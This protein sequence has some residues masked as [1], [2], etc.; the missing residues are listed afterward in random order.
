M[1]S[2]T[3]NSLMSTVLYDMSSH[4]DVILSFSHCSLFAF[5][6]LNITDLLEES[7][8][9]QPTSFGTVCFNEYL[10]LVFFICYP[11]RTRHRWP[12]LI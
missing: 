10:F 9:N 7:A 11:M 6:V 12:A 1:D 2:I 3:N 5:S 4:G 8:R